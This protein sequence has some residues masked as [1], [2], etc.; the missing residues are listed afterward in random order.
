MLIEAWWVTVKVD[1]VL[2][3]H[4]AD[5]QSRPVVVIVYAHVVRPSGSLMT[6]V[7]FYLFSG[8]DAE[9]AT[10]MAMAKTPVA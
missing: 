8:S 9:S 2:L 1:P 5:P 4:S 3:I 10:S 6:P 7:L